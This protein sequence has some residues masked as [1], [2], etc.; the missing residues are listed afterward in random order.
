MSNIFSIDQ[1]GYTNSLTISA[2][3]AVSGS[4][5]IDGY[6]IDPD[7]AVSG[8]VLAYDGYEFSP[9][10]IASGVSGSFSNG[11]IIIG[12]VANSSVIGSSNLTFDGYSLGVN[13]IE[14]VSGGTPIITLGAATGHYGHASCSIVGTDAAGTITFT[15]GTYTGGGSGGGDQ[16][17]V[18]S[19]VQTFNSPPVVIITSSNENA[20]LAGGNGLYIIQNN[21]TNSEFILETVGAIN[22]GTYQYNYFVI[23]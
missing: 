8:Q 2:N 1:D 23:G 19:F 20:G 22:S 17:A 3:T 21:V 10:T 13:H 14:R 7:G 18:V 12:D 5:S 15:L 11:Q 4:F 6:V 9:Q 16:M